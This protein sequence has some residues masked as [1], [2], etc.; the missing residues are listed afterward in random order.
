MFFLE[1]SSESHP[2]ADSFRNYDMAILKLR[3]PIDFS[4]SKYNHIR[5]ACLPSEVIPNNA[6]VSN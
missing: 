4:D 5:P 1:L 6:E 3:E 2:K